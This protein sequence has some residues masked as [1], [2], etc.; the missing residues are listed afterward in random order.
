MNR[1]SQSSKPWKRSGDFPFPRAGDRSLAVHWLVI[2][3]LLC[4]VS[5]Q[6]GG[7]RWH[8]NADGDTEG[9]IT[10]NM[11]NIS[12]SN[13]LFSM[14]VLEDPF[15]ISPDHLGLDLSGISNVTIHAKNGSALSTGTVFF[16]TDSASGFAGNMVSFNLVANDPGFTTYTVDMSVHSNWTGTLKQL[17]FDIPDGNAAGSSVAVDWVAVGNAGLRPNVL[18]VMADDLG[19]NDT[20]IN[21]STFYHTP[22]LERLAERGVRLT[23]AYTASPLCSPTRASILTGRDPGRLRLTTPS[24]HLEPVVLDPVVQA[25][26]PSQNKL[27]VPGSCTRLDNAYVTYA[28]TMQTAGYATAFMGKWHLGRDPYIP[29]NQGFET[30]VGGRHHSGP[31]GSY[32]APFSSDSNLPTAPDGTHVNDLLVDQSLDFLSRKRNEPFLLNLWFYDVHAPFECKESLRTS[33][34][35]KASDDGRQKNPTMGAMVEAMDIGLGRVL[36]QVDALGLAENTIVIF[37]S[38]NGGNM[39]DWED[40]SLMTHNWPL[41]SGKGSVYEG[42]THVPCVVVW[43]GHTT[44]GAVSDELLQSPD[45]YPTIL[46]LAGLE[47]APGAALDAF[48]QTNLLSGGTSARTN[49]FCHFPHIGSSSGCMPAC[50]VRQGDWKLLRFFHD[51]PAWS[52]R[53]ELYNLSADPHESVDLSGLNPALVAQLDVALDV[54]LADTDPLLPVPNEAY[55]PFDFGWQPNTQVRLSL[56]DPG[57][58]L[59]TANGFEARIESTDDLS[60]LGAPGQLVVT[61]QSRSL[62]DGWLFWRMPGETDFSESNSVSFAVVHDDT[63]RTYDIP[64]T[65]DEPIVQLAFQPSSDVSATEIESIE[66]YSALG[67]R[68]KTWRW[69]DSDGDGMTDLSE[70]SAGRDPTH[71]A[72]MAFHFETDGDFEGWSESLK[73]I[74]N[75]AVSNGAVQ[76]TALTIDPYFANYSVDFSGADVPVITLRVRAGTNSN[77]QFFW[78]NENGGFDAVRRENRAYT[79]NG[80]WQVLEFDLTAHPEWDGRQ[81]SKLR[82]DPLTMVSWFEI[83]WI[84]AANG[85]ADNDGFPDWAEETAGT[86]RLDPSENQFTSSGRVPVELAGL[87]GRTYT[88]QWSDS[89]TPADWSVVESVGPLASDQTVVFTNGTPSTQGF[90]RV[91]VEKQ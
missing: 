42:G 56:L 81:I 73:N 55:A 43:P 47:P 49:A 89:L 2:A 36:D 66:L 31:P 85:D 53:Y 80:E 60:D 14:T 64:F 10:R 61:M 67:A 68:L 11:E 41:R 54:F 9:W 52:H 88:L 4:A 25:T 27:R 45:W 12:V 13:G 79:G 38:D 72:D 20:S 91:L 78:A 26:A 19:W 17:R 46:E 74:E 35:G 58:M 39:Y 5:S 70:I 76:G 21:G 24:G 37:F 28:E 44:P 51:G 32:F 18:F 77:V 8:W 90:Y 15:A 59:L 82:V 48:S 50:W 69:Q 62:G 57:R 75:F 6:A 30:V 23:Q 65:P 33:Y 83:D 87:S 86:G 1:F 16:Q 22:S 84:R 40:G 63:L 3:W 7:L 34:L 71:S 29:E